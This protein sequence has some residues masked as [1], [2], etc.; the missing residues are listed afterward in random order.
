[1]GTMLKC[2]PSCLKKWSPSCDCKFSWCKVFISLCDKS[3]KNDSGFHE[4][5]DENL[6]QTPE[7]IRSSPKTPSAPKQMFK[8]EKTRESRLRKKS[9]K[10]GFEYWDTSIQNDESLNPETTEAQEP[11]IAVGPVTGY[12]SVYPHFATPKLVQ[13][14]DGDHFF[15]QLGRHFSIVIQA[16]IKHGAHSKAIVK[17]MTAAN[18]WEG[19]IS[20]KSANSPSE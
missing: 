20:S 3:R 9:L 19:F 6:P 7:Q 5:F 18:T 16:V 2:L 15:K 4:T 12:S 13:S 14:Q 8:R 1:M 17:T 10:S 11:P